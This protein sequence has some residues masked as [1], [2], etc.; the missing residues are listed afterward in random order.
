M[1][2]KTVVVG[3]DDEIE[4]AILD[5]SLADDENPDGVA[6]D[7]VANGVTEMT[8]EFNGN[9]FSSNN[10]EISYEDEGKIKLRLGMIDAA[11]YVK[12]R[13]YPAT[14]KAISSQ[15]PNGQ[16]VVAESNVDSS[17]SLVFR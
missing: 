13:A 16:T 6:I 8:I 10:G 1:T 15:F 2:T 3:S 9:T 12:F 5:Q 7:F 14:I 11:A 17:L 4:I